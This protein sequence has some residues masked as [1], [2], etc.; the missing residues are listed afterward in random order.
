MADSPD[1]FNDR[2]RR[3]RRQT[4]HELSN[5]HV[6]AVRRDVLSR[7]YSYIS[8]D[9]HA[10]VLAIIFSRSYANE[11]AGVHEDQNDLADADS[12]T[13]HVPVHNEYGDW[14]PFRDVF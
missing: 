10:Y 7:F 11:Y 3:R 2:A 8:D 6:H 13:I 9:D 5:V 12:F 14:N 1:L 4:C